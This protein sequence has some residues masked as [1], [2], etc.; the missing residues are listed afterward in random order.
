MA[1]KL[2][3]QEEGDRAPVSGPAVFAHHTD[4]L[5]PSTPLAMLAPLGLRVAPRRLRGRPEGRG[6]DFRSA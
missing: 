5:A 3:G 1:H 4:M 2:A 6:F